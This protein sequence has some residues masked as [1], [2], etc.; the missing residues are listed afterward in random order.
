MRGKPA[1]KR[2]IKSDAKF[3]REDIAKFINYIMQR[4]KK[5]V[6][7][8]IVYEALDIVS[9]KTKADPLDIF[10]AAIKNVSPSVEI[11]GR[12]VGGANYQVPMAVRPERSFALGCRWIIDAAS[13]RKGKRMAEKLAEEFMAAYNNEGSAIKKKQDTYRMAEANRAFAHFSR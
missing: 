7:K 1:P 3:S 8:G 13:S 11:K 2:T 5:N 6:A 4:G 10:S 12:R 9:E